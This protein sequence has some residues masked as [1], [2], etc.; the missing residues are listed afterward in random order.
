MT[1]WILYLLICTVPKFTENTQA[2][3]VTFKQSVFIC[4]YS[5]SK[6]L[7]ALRYRAAFEC[8][9]RVGGSAISKKMRQ[10][11]VMLYTCEAN[12]F[13]TLTAIH[14]YHRI[15]HC[16]QLCIKI[17]YCIWKVE[18]FINVVNLRT[19]GSKQWYAKTE[20]PH[21]TCNCKSRQTILSHAWQHI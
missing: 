12:T 14:T 8:H 4:Y 2:H 20:Y 11:L 9:R 1:T 21:V 15:F 5:L 19:D 7:F 13:V 6:H 10:V 18:L 3:E 17:N 16:L